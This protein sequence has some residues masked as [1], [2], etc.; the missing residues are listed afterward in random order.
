MAQLI[1]TTPC[2]PLM[3]HWPIFRAGEKTEA[4]DPPREQMKTWTPP[5]CL[6][7]GILFHSGLLRSWFFAGRVTVHTRYFIFI[8]HARLK[9][10]LCPGWCAWELCAELL[11]SVFSKK[12]KKVL[13][14]GLCGWYSFPKH[15]AEKRGKE[16]NSPEVLR[17]LLSGENV[18]LSDMHLVGKLGSTQ[19]RPSSRGAA[20][21]TKAG[22]DD[23][24]VPCIPAP[25]ER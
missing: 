3:G 22:L 5:V 25:R 24:E 14:T 8:C 19:N 17:R 21:G 20:G 2:Y 16:E 11:A 9:T 15:R 12:K 1:E 18:L 10:C 23:G 7:S 13:F 4:R 6:P